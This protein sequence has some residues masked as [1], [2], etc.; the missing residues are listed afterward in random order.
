[1]MLSSRDQFIATQPIVD[2]YGKQFANELLYRDSWQNCYP[3]GLDESLATYRLVIN[4]LLVHSPQKTTRGELAFLNCCSKTIMEKIPML[5]NPQQTI[6]EITERSSDLDRLLV[7]MV[8][9]KKHG[10]R[11]ALDDYDGDRK[12]EKILQEVEFV[13]LEVREQPDKTVR[14]IQELK[15]AFPNIRIVVERIE[16]DSIF[17]L[18]KSAGADYFQGYLFSKPLVSKIPHLANSKLVTLQLLK[19]LQSI[20]LNFGEICKTIGHDAGLYLRL[21]RHI[22][23]K[24]APNETK[25]HTI[26]HAIV[27]TGEERLRNFLTVMCISELGNDVACRTILDSLTRAIFVK[28]VLDEYHSPHGKMGYA[29]ALVSKLDLVLETEI[30]TIVDNLCLPE[31]YTNIIKYNQGPIGGLLSFCSIQESTGLNLH[32]QIKASKLGVS[33][34]IKHYLIASKYARKF[35]HIDEHSA[36]KQPGVEIREQQC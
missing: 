28:N 34:L 18:F 36:S 1:M 21:L 23:T 22:N 6:I 2:K 7:T 29:V 27:Y 16:S 32:K 14:L 5:L 13:K 31:S 25:F 24:F 11:F 30:E 35:F 9:M 26:E 4:S 12:W 15:I 10:Y 3:K 8:S 20:E 19:Q 17:N 33:N